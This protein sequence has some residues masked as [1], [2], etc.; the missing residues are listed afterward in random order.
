MPPPENTPDDVYQLMMHCWD[1]DPKK[2][3]RF[4]DIHNELQ[5]FFHSV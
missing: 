5:Q 2:R 1:H 3:P 4:C